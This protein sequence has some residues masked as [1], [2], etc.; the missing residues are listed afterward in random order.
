[1]KNYKARGCGWK[2][3]GHI[4]ARGLSKEEMGVQG[5]KMPDFIIDPTWLVDPKKD[6]GLAAQGI[7]ILPRPDGSNIYDAYDWVGEA[8]YPYASDFI[9]EADNLD[10]TCRLI[11]KETPN[12]G[13]LTLKSKH[14][15]GFPKG[16]IVN[17]DPL[18][19]DYLAIMPCPIHN[20]LH[21]PKERMW[22]TGLLWEALG[23]S[24]MEYYPWGVERKIVIPMP[25]GR[26]ENGEKYPEAF[27]Y[28]GAVEPEKME[29]KYLFGF[30]YWQPIP[31]LEVV[32]DPIEGQHEKAI[33]ALQDCGCQIP[34]D[35]TE[36]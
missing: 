36:G 1:M 10:G 32:Y 30:C 27:R 3:T 23:R 20:E 15:F 16:Q 24:A 33:Q 31:R 11:A 35:I 14:F 8:N 6:L 5:V 13:M 12:L 34:F 17:Y 29:R 2:R 25:R 28:S 9:M 4:Y 19:D 26:D 18:W 21:T 22:C 7:R